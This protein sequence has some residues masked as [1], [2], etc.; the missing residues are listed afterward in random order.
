MCWTGVWRGGGEIEAF[1]FLPR[2][3]PTFCLNSILD[4]SFSKV[5]KVFVLPQHLANWLCLL[6]PP[7]THLPL[8]SRS[9][10]G[11][12]VVSLGAAFHISHSLLILE[13]AS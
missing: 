6:P 4:F 11:S 8:D 5:F 2:P 12:S 7:R 3:R 13:R 9:H 1:R 10:T